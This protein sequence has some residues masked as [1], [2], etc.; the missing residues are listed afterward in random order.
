MKKLM[1]FLITAAAIFGLT[2]S[3]A[4]AVKLGLPIKGGKGP[5]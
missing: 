3:P 4:L 1:F 2:A 5:N